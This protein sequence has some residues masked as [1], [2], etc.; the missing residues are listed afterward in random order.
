MYIYIVYM[1]DYRNFY[2][3]VFYMY[4]EIKFKKIYLYFEILIYMVNFKIYI[5]INKN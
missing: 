1:Y 5:K 2:I 4:F 3:M